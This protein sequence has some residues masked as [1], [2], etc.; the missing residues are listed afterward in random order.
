MYEYICQTIAFLTLKETLQKSDI[1]HI[2]ADYGFPFSQLAFVIHASLN[3][4]GHEI[5]RVAQL[6]SS[7][8]DGED[9]NVLG[10][11]RFGL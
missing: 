9:Q 1:F 4:S 10:Q 8:S 7:L 6:N 5:N 11:I 2:L 3:A